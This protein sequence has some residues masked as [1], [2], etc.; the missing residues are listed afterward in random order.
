MNDDQLR[1]A[2]GC[3][4][5]QLA[6]DALGSMVEF[7][8]AA[9]IARLHPHGLRQIG[10]SPQWDTIAGQPTDDSEMAL[11]LART[12][13]QHGCDDEAIANAYDQWNRSGRFDCGRTIGRALAG[14][15]ARRG[16]TGAAQAA[17]AAADP[18]SQGN[19][20]MMRQSPLAIWGYRME[21]MQLAACVQADTTLTHPNQA[22]Q[23][24]S[25]AYV[26]AMAAAIR[27]GLDAQ[28]TYQ[29]ALDWQRQ[30]GKDSNITETLIAAATQLPTEY[31]HQMGWV[32]IALQ[33]A[34]YYLLHEAALEEGVIA[35]VMHG[36]D[37]DTNAA[38]AGALLGAVY[39]VDA[40]PSQ[41][42]EAV[43][44]CQPVA[45][46]GVAN[47]RPRIYWPSDALE[48]AAQLLAAHLQSA[49]CNPQP[50]TYN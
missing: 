25:A 27:E 33:N 36:G 50:T 44:N 15:G 40:I 43:L 37:T 13:L 7:K 8:P 17:R 32:R 45:G 2:Q 26:L 35:T 28:A 19:G 16:G 31:Q 38:I 18:T 14:V 4:L 1:R 47:P 24:A 46:P 10:P 5:G 49:G 41:W 11:A 9:E 20:A 30:H 12:L 22:C 48:L 34:F 21:P 39:G 3:L 42:R 23:D 29:Y 6:G